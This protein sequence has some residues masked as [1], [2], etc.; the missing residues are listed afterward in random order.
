MAISPRGP[1]L[2]GDG[3]GAGYATDT[4][5]REALH[6]QPA[7]RDLVIGMS[8][9]VVLGKGTV[10]IKVLPGALWVIAPEAG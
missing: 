3:K 8:D 1:D 7:I 9:G 4:A 10:K 2:A 5:H 6:G